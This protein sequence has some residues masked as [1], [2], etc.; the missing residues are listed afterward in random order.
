MVG[1]NDYVIQV[2]GNQGK[3]LKGIKEIVQ[4]NE[5]ENFVITEDLKRGRVE[6]RIV[7]I[8]K[9]IEKLDSG[10]HGLKA[11]IK[12]TNKGERN[13][14]QYLKEHYYITSRDDLTAL[15]FAKGV[16]GHWSIENQLH[17]V[18]DAI[19]KED[20]CL[21]KTMRLA[22]NMSLIRSFVIN[23]FRLNGHRSIKKAI[24]VYVNRLD[25]GIKLIHN[26]YI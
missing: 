13:K 18:K 14:N 2:K 21:M 20:N 10:W 9:Q 11:V 22:S 4:K 17:W 16:R 5:A 19:L 6:Y 24:E 23:L 7:Q 26:S 1:G 15:E 3:L 25:K 8:Y 12:V